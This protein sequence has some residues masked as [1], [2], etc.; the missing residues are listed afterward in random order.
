MGRYAGRYTGIRTPRPTRQ[1]TLINQILENTLYAPLPHNPASPEDISR[2]VSNHLW[3]DITNTTQTLCPITQELFVFDDR[4]S[5]ID[6]CGH[7]FIEDALTTYLTEFD[8][9]CPACR[10][11]I[12]TDSHGDISHGDISQ[13]I[14]VIPVIPVPIRRARRFYDVSYNVQTE[15]VPEQVVGTDLNNVINNLANTMVSSLTTAINNADNSG[16]TVSTEYSILFP[17]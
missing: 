6:Y 12:R 17:R 7:L 9:R 3:R 13:N 5:R 8:H 15:L 14:P 1:S 11:N 10:Y 16:N 4:V 2:N